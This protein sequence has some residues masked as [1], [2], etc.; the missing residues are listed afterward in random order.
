MTRD[1]ASRD[2]E[3][4]HVQTARIAW[5]ASAAVGGLAAILFAAA[6]DNTTLALVFAVLSVVLAVTFGRGGR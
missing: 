4:Q 3:K 2:R 1:R 5:W 6:A